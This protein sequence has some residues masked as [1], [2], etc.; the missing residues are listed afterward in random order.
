MI[1]F[2]FTEAL[3]IFK[4]SPLASIIVISITT[5]AILL[6]S[7]SFY[8]VFIS[9]Q[10][11]NRVKKNIELVAYLDE[12]IDSL[13]LSNAQNQ[14]QSFGFISSVRFVS[15]EDALNEFIRDTGEDIRSVLDN[16]PLPQSFVIKLK[17]ELL[18]KEN[19]EPEVQAIKS[20]PGVS[21]VD[22]ENEF[23]VK[24][25]HYLKSGQLIVYAVSALLV[26][27]SVYLVYVYSKLQFTANENL[28][29]IMKLVGAKLL[30]LK[31]PILMY[32]ILIG[33]ISGLISLCVNAAI[34]YLINKI[35]MNSYFPIAVNVIYFSSIGLGI[36]LGFLGSYLSAKKITLFVG[37]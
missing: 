14:I 4:R 11:S 15:K 19:I 21:D 13:K 3:R 30:T 5:I 28:Y 33:L 18:T 32:G 29:R 24:I 36:V 2:Y 37:E 1:S 31:L 10:L 22:Y 7:I 20:V 34:I 17:P 12:T 23:V 25:L 8:L 16:N 9:Q 6:S 26:L 35:L 27:L